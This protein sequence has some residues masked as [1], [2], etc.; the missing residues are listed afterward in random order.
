MSNEALA[1]AFANA[2]ASFDTMTPAQQVH[3]RHLQRISFA[4]GNL[5]MSSRTRT[6]DMIRAD[7]ERA[8]GPCPCA[9]CK[10]T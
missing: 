5:A 8:A 9:D 1:K 6:A 4:T 7:V 3:H 10:V 2:L